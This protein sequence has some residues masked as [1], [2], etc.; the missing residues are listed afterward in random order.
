MLDW[1]KCPLCRTS[2]RTMSFRLR[3]ALSGSVTARRESGR[4]HYCQR[5]LEHVHSRG[6]LH[7]ALV[8]TAVS[9][10]QQG[11]RQRGV[12]HRGV[13]SSKAESI[14]KR[15]TVVDVFAA[16]SVRQ[17]LMKGGVGGV[18]AETGCYNTSL[19][20]VFPL[21][22][23]LLPETMTQLSPVQLILLFQF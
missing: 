21:H 18:G 22:H 7:F 11:N 5:H 2:G 6:F 10:R 23:C 17:E 15:A 19:L 9:K 20:S 13:A 14:G 16:T 12:A 8:C 4:T 3:T 1:R